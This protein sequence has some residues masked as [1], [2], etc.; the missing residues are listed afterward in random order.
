MVEEMKAHIVSLTKRKIKENSDIKII[1]VHSG[2]AKI[3][4]KGDSV[5]NC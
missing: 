2:V 4:G 1:F 3:F 5:K